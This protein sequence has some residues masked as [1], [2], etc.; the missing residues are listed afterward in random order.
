MAYVSHLRANA[1]RDFAV[2]L[3]PHT[4]ILG[5]N[6]KGKTAIRDG[7]NLALTGTVPGDDLG[8]T[9]TRLIQLA[10]DGG[11]L[12][13]SEATLS[14]GRKQ[15]F[16]LNRGKAIPKIDRLGVFVDEAVREIMKTEDRRRAALLKMMSSIIPDL[17]REAFLKRIPNAFHEEW[18][19]VLEESEKKADSLEFADVLGAAVKVVKSRKRIASVV[20]KDAMADIEAATGWTKSDEEE[21]A[22]LRASNRGLSDVAL[23]ENQQE[24]VRRNRM[25]L[26]SQL[27]G[28]EDLQA[29]TQAELDLLMLLPAIRA[30]Q[31]VINAN[32]S[33]QKCL[34]CGCVLPSSFDEGFEAST[35]NV[36]AKKIKAALDRVLNISSRQERAETATKIQVALVETERILA[37]PRPVDSEVPNTARITELEAQQRQAAASVDAKERGIAAE[38]QLLALKAIEGAL[39]K[40]TDKVLAGATEK[41]AAEASQWLPGG[42]ALAVDL[43]EKGKPVCKLGLRDAKN[44]ALTRPWATLSGVERYL[45][46]GALSRFQA[47]RETAPVRL[48]AVDEIAVSKKNLKS[49]LVALGAERTNDPITQTIVFAVLDEDESFTPP[50]GWSVV[51]VK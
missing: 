37:L 3:S 51:T 6:F 31:V 40:L 42:T 7:L 44:G 4:L 45:V 32:T 5:D 18:K 35:A 38:K 41:F 19:S 11:D 49:M 26:Q 17:S 14:D 46:I 25:A 39:E 1:K 33:R 47:A 23:W 43:W 10:A 30:A 16:K 15:E 21:L 34:V 8:A 22:R 24:D 27:A 2:D 13:F 36:Q 29:P 28:L 20:A 12:L 50:P 48:L 9:G